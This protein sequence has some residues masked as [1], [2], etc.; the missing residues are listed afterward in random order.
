MDAPLPGAL[1]TPLH[2]CLGY[3]LNPDSTMDSQDQA[4]LEGR[5]P[6]TEENERARFRELHRVDIDPNSF[7]AFVTLAGLEKVQ[8]YHDRLEAVFRIVISNGRPKE[9]CTALWEALVVSKHCSF[10]VFREALLLTEEKHPDQIKEFLRLAYFHQYPKHDSSNLS[11]KQMADAIKGVVAN[12]PEKPRD[13]ESV[14]PD[15]SVDIVKAGFQAEYKNSD[16]IVK[17]NLDLLRDMA[18][19]WSQINYKA[20]FTSIVGPTMSGKT[21]LL[22]EFAKHVCVVYIC[23]RP[24]DS[25]GQPPRSSLA[26]T[27]LPVDP[28]LKSN[29]HLHYSRF[30]AAILEAVADFF[31]SANMQGRKS[32]D[33]L[34]A[35]FEHSFQMDEKKKPDKFSSDVRAKMKAL[36]ATPET[37]TM[38]LVEDAA[39]KMHDSIQ[40]LENGKLKLVLAID[41]ARNLLPPEDETFKISYFQAFCWVLSQIPPSK[42]FFAVFTDT[43]SKVANSNPPASKD[44]SLR[45]PK[46][47]YKLFPPIY[48]LATLDLMARPIPESWKELLSPLRLFSYGSPFYGLYFEAAKNKTPMGAIEVTMSIATEKLLCTTVTPSAQELSKS[49][50]FALLGSTIQTRLTSSDMNAELISS[51]AAHCMFIS[52]SRDLIISYYPSQFIYASAANAFLASDD[53]IM[54]TCIDCLA[55]SMQN[56]L[57]SRGDAGEMATRII[58]LRAMHKTKKIMCDGEDSIPYG[59]SVRLEDF[60]ETLTGVN[61]QQLHFGPIK[62]APKNRLLR[63]GR[64]FFNHFTLVEYTPNATDLLELLYRGLAVQCKPGQH[65]LNELFPI[66]LPPKSKSP[67]S[68]KLSHKNISFCGI[69]TKNQ[70]DSTDWS[71]SHKWSKSGAGIKDIQNPYLILLFSLRSE[72]KPDT[73]C[74]KKA[75][76]EN[77]PEWKKPLDNTDQQRAYLNFLGLDRIACLTPKIRTALKRLLNSTPEDILPLHKPDHRTLPDTHTLEW[78]RRQNPMFYDRRNRANVYPASPGTSITRETRKLHLQVST[79]SLSQRASKAWVSTTTRPQPLRP[80]GRCGLLVTIISNLTKSLVS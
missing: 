67:D 63:N 41:E 36:P 38:N 21:R 46:R 62:N 42:G 71:D 26:D 35:W 31:S 13:S 32:E 53:E 70:T 68:D 45:I 1:P 54:V 22:L 28:E 64:I 61:P 48:K 27:L 29:L 65:G 10:N 58:L 57:I 55:T 24:P 69:Q 6:P 49:Q 39:K 11:N 18:G 15:W 47:G 75:P 3:P 77:P 51:N 33:Q 40:F 30:L 8:E 37:E 56:G 74:L 25:S 76:K 12:K 19:A 34:A 4:S 17:P 14:H 80:P 78:I 5:A 60:L 23:I 43:I 66:Y 16:L 52:S 2:H 7:S 73:T 44:P 79:P 50:V 20:P 72:D 9:S 59:Y